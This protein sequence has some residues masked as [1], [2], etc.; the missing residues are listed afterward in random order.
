MRTA[1]ATFGATPRNLPLMV[2]LTAG[3]FI[4][5]ENASD[6]FANDTER[7]AHRVEYFQRF[8]ARQFS[9]DGR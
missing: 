7:P 9:G 3:E 6:K 4:M 8:F 1:P 2:K 5:G